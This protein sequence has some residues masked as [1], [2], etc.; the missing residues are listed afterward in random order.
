MSVGIPWA[1]YLKPVIM[2]RRKK[3]TQEA[4][5]RGEFARP[6]RPETIVRGR[7]AP[8]QPQSAEPVEVKA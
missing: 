6:A 1:F 7:E 8:A 3:K 2:K 4:L 5:A